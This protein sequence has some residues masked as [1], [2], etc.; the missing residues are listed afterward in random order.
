MMVLTNMKLLPE[1]ETQVLL[2]KNCNI[3]YCKFRANRTTWCLTEINSH[4]FAF[5]FLNCRTANRD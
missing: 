4:S 5:E 2:K 3:A 1:L